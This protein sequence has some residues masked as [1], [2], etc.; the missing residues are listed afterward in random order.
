MCGSEEVGRSFDQKTN[1]TMNLGGISIDKVTEEVWEIKH[2]D[3]LPNK[4]QWMMS[5]EM[6]DNLAKGRD[7]NCLF[8]DLQ[9]YQTVSTNVYYRQYGVGDLLGRNKKNYE[10]NQDSKNT[11]NVVATFWFSP[12]TKSFHKMIKPNAGAWLRIVVNEAVHHHITDWPNY[13]IVKY[14]KVAEEID[15]SFNCSGHW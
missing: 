13:N 8:K 15:D 14:A 9:L 2:K 10:R 6:F 1:V 12:G 4:N 11:F 3:P 5:A 7:I